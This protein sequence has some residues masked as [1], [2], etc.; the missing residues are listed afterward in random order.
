[1]ATLRSTA[2]GTSGTGPGTG[3]GTGTVPVPAIPLS[4]RIVG[5]GDGGRINAKL[6]QVELPG[7]EVNGQIELRSDRQLQ[8][9][10]SGRSS[11]IGQLISSV[12]SL[13]GQSD[14]SLLRVP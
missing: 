6:L 5:R 8:G 2:S 7:A 3:T 12:E 11:D 9:E 1:D 4:G 14:G 10:V 13:T